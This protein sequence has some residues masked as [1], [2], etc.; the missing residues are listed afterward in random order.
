[1]P[2]WIDAPGAEE[3]VLAE[4]PTTED[5]IE[6]YT[7]VRKLEHPACLL[8]Y[9]FLDTTKDAVGFATI[10]HHLHIKRQTAIFV[11]NI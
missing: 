10:R 3:T 4:A 1:M 5:A 9:Y 7:V 2:I 8:I 6:N 11:V